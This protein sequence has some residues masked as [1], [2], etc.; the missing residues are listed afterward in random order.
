[1]RLLRKQY[2][3]SGSKVDEFSAVKQSLS[4]SI[5]LNFTRNKTS[6]QVYRKREQESYI[7]S[8]KGINEKQTEGELCRVLCDVCPFFSSSDQ[9]GW[10]FIRK[11]NLLCIILCK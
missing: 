6:M 3:Y 9:G 10:R 1:M 4:M 2:T 8:T 7:I 5:C 11:R